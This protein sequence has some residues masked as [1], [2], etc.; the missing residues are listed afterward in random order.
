MSNTTVPVPFILDGP[1][2]P[3]EY[4]VCLNDARGPGAS[5]PV[6]SDPNLIAQLRFLDVTNAMHAMYLMALK[7]NHG[8]R[9]SMNRSDFRL[10]R[11]DNEGREVVAWAWEGDQR[12]YED[13]R[14]RNDAHERVMKRRAQ[15]RA[16]CG[17]SK[18]NPGWGDF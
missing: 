11:V 2:A 1:D 17:A 6:Q 3:V 13:F 12:A 5:H 10:I 14:E 4:F 18:A 15:A 16:E 8:L 7:P 9:T